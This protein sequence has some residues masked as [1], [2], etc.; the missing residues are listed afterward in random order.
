MPTTLSPANTPNA[1]SNSCDT[2]QTSRLAPETIWSLANSMVAIVNVAPGRN[3]TSGGASSR[4]AFSCVTGPTMRTDST[5]TRKAANTGS[6]T[7]RVAQRSAS[8]RSRPTNAPSA[9]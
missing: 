9:T 8:S 4:N 6:A 7:D 3:T 2:P 1:S 5:V